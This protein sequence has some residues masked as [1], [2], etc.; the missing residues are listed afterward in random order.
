MNINTSNVTVLTP[1]L[2]GCHT[3]PSPK[4]PAAQIYNPGYVPDG[5]E[6]Q[7]G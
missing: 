1:K 6:L 4:I 2:G 3:C 7:S 5:D